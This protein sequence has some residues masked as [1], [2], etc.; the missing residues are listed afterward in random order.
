MT[1]ANQLIKILKEKGLT[2]SLAES[3]TCGLAAHKLS[4]AKG[5]SDVLVGSIVCYTPQ[6]KMSLLNIKKHV[7]EKCTCESMEVTEGLAKNLSGL[8]KADVYAAVTGLA[9]EGGSETK[10]K[11][12]GTVFFSVVYKRKAYNSRKLFR[13]SPSEIKEKACLE[14]YRLILDVVQSVQ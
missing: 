11:P 6:V 8:M 5:V 4:T 1:K 7:I 12:V 2:L 14:L 13:G 10:E 9:S 3:I